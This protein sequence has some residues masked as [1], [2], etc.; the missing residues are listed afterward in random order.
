MRKAVLALVATL[1][2]TPAILAQQPAWADKLFAGET[3]HDFGTVVRGA[4]LKYSFKMTNIYK[5]PL[6]ITK[7]HVS[8]GC[9]KAEASSQT[10]QPNETATVNITMDGRQF[11]GTTKTVRIFVS[12]GPKFISTATLTV[13]A[14]ARGDVAFSPTELD[15][16]NLHRGQTP[17]K[18]IDIEYVGGK[19]DWRVV[20]IVKNGSAPFELKVEE[21][22]RLLSGPAR[23]GYRIMAAIKADAATGSFKQEVVLKT[24]DL[25]AP[26]LTFN[27]VGNVQA[28]LAVSPSP[29]LVRD[30][31]VGESQTKKVFIRA[32]RPFRVTAV[33]GQGDGISVEIPDRQDTTLVLTVNVNPLKAG[34]LRRQLMIRTNLDDDATPLMIEA[35]IE[36]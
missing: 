24:N 16:G 29:I 1:T 28:G 30:L 12:V 10:L 9:V 21:L 6:E 32:S 15:F 35:T 25:A 13:S 33:E 36:P 14:N 2:F 19:I 5:V 34:D 8:C 11:V 17:T 20:E 23:K 3:T 27:I 7:V 31:K 4:Q 26:V 18:P 22:P